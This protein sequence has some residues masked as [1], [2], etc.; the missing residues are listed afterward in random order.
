MLPILLALTVA[1]TA[2]GGDGRKDLRVFAAASLVDVF[3]DLETLFESSHPDVDVVI[4]AGGSTQLATQ[5]SEGAPADVFAAANETAME[6]V[7]DSPDGVFATNQLVIVTPPNNPGGVD[8]IEDLADRDLVLAI[9]AP[10]VPCGDLTESVFAEAGV[11]AAAD[12]EEPNVRAVLNKVVLDEV[13]V[14]LVYRSDAIAAGE[15]VAT[16]GIDS[17]RSNKYPIT[18][19]T[20]SGAAAEFVELVESAQAAAIFEEA[21]FGAP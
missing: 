17:E 4:Q 12:T 19:L 3:S 7:T 13:D 10:E 8:G 15:S 18:T 21:G 16:L 14:G 5:I 2:C 11:A 6:L 20:E 9:C 1:G